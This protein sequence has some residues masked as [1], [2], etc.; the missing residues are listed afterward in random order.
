MENIK[1][2]YF[3][4]LKV[5]PS[6]KRSGQ[7]NNLTE[8]FSGEEM[9]EAIGGL[10]GKQTVLVKGNGT[11][12]ENG[13]ELVA[14]YA[15]A[16]AANKEAGTRFTVLV[17]PGVYEV[18]S[19]LLFD[20]DYV[21]VISL[22]SNLP[23]SV[24]ITGFGIG[25]SG[26]FSHMHGLSTGNNRFR[27]ESGLTEFS[28]SWCA[29]GNYSFGGYKTGESPEDANFNGTFFN[30]EAGVE[31]FG[32]MSTFDNGNYYDCTGSNFCFGSG[33]ISLGFV[34]RCTAGGGSYGGFNSNRSRAGSASGQ[35][36]DCLAF[37][38]S[39]GGG[40]GGSATGK[41]IL[42]ESGANS[43]GSD[44]GSFTGKAH[45]CIANGN[46]SFNTPGGTI[47]FT[48]VNGVAI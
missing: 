19:E 11:P 14:A 45:Y 16:K 36:V 24:V 23:A 30:C 12:T 29:G 43:F 38:D 41:F 4:A 22:A 48:S 3:T 25:C 6:E 27:V 32:T 5:K 28:A 33:S 35:Y 15:T 10:N 34:E 37:N 1:E 26:S 13:A 7:I 17:T 2:M 8:I 39:F 46:G 31:S 20:A 9:A 40:A 42:C 44:S 18:T 47:L 21:N